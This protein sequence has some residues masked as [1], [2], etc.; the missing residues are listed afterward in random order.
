MPLAPNGTGQI[1]WLVGPHLTFWL[2][3]S[4]KEE[5]ALSSPQPYP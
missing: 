5:P 4:L 1:Q 2:K 3:D